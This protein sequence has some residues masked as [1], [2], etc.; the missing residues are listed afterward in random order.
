MMSDHQSTYEESVGGGGDA[1]FFE[2][3]RNRLIQDISKGVESILGNAND[4]NR[5]LE[6]SISVGKEFHPISE[7][8]SKFEKIM[9]ASGIPNLYPQ[10]VASSLA[11]TGS[12]GEGANGAGNGG[13]DVI[14]DVVAATT[15]K[16]KSSNQDG[17]ADTEG[18]LDGIR[19]ET[20]QSTLPPGVAPGGG[21][22]YA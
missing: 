5:K 8:W 22:I 17:T 7:L 4:L 13:E 21:R 6:E 18:N 14:A 16:R 20:N 12:G 2:R 19:F 11:P 15:P 1:G 9:V 3:E 10:S